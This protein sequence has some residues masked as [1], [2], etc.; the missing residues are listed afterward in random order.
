MDQKATV[1]YKF[2]VLSAKDAAHLA[3]HY[4]RCTGVNKGKAIRTAIKAFFVRKV[5]ISNKT[6]SSVSGKHIVQIIEKNIQKRNCVNAR[7]AF[8]LFKGEARKMENHVVVHNWTTS[9]SCLN[10]HSALSLKDQD[11]KSD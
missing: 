5:S 9:P 7:R 2:T 11:E 8:Y 1:T 3:Y 4:D 10:R 6:I